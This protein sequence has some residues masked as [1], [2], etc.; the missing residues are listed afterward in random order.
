MATYLY[1]LIPYDRPVEPDSPEECFESF[2]SIPQLRD[3]E[4]ELVDPRIL[5]LFPGFL[6]INTCYSMCMILPHEGSSNSSR[7]EIFKIVRALG[8]S[9]AWY[10]EELCTDPMFEDNEYSL[11]KFKNQM[12]G[13]IKDYSTEYTKSLV[14]T[15]SYIHD[16]FNDLMTPDTDSRPVRSLTDTIK[17]V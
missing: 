4:S 7:K 9:E 3:M 12:K 5:Y 11:E 17:N 15:A 10:V 6:L 14:E 16:D 2:P 8:A 1:A 13:E